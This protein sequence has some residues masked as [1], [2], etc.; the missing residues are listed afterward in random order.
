MTD[1]MS[2]SESEIQCND[3][4]EFDIPRNQKFGEEIYHTY[5]LRTYVCNFILRSY[6]YSIYSDIDNLL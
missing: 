6:L 1:H 2:T 4:P 3:K 5:I